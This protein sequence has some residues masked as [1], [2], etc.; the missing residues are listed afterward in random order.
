MMRS[1]FRSFPSAIV[2]AVVLA[3]A[4]AHMLHAQKLKQRVADKHAEVFDYPAMA[5]IYQGMADKGKA[6]AADLRRLAIAYKRMGRMDLAEGTYA[7]LTGASQAPQD[8]L[9]Y[10]EVLRANG[11]YEQAVEWYGR[12]LAQNPDDA[13]AQ[14]Y[15]QNP[16]LFQRLE[17]AEAGTVR[18]V[19]INSPQADLG[20][21]VLG[22]LLI[23]S[24]ARGEGVGGRS[25]YKWDLEPYLNLYSAMLKGE[26]VESPMVM[27]KELNSRY[28]DGTVSY[29]SLAHRLYFTRNNLHYGTKSLA[30]NGELKLGIYFSDVV[31]GQFGQK[32]WGVLIPFDH[33]DP[34]HNYGHPCVSH[35]GRRLYFVSDRPGGF[36]GTDI[37]Y[38]DNL[39][40]NWGA[41]QNLGPKVNTPGNEMHPFITGTGFLYFASNGHPGLGGLD[42]FRTKITEAGAGRVFN[43]GAPLNTR[44][45]DFGLIL[46]KDD[47]TGFFVSD[48]PGGQ[49]SDDIYG[50]TVR[51]PMMFLA[52]IVIDANTR[53]PIEGATILLKDGDNQHVK[54]FQ[55]ET[56]PGGRFKID[57]EYRTQYVLVANKNGYY[58]KEV[59]VNTDS[60]P[61]ED[62]VI[63]MVKYDYAAEGLVLH[64]E[65]EQPL[66][67]ATVRL[68]DGNDQLLE[69]L[70][71]DASGKYNFPLKPESD[72]R[73][74][75]ERDGFFKQSARIS[76][77]GK[78]SA[79]IY[80]DFRLF[81]LDVGTIVRLENI[82]YDYNKWNIRPDAALELDKLVLTL[83]DNPT[84][85]IELGS[86]TDCRGKDAYNMGLSEKRAKSAVDYIISKGIAKDRVRSKGYGESKPYVDCVCEKCT[87]EQHQQNRRTEFTVLEK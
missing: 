63:E 70:V 84:V 55:L 21:A 81:P 48:R 16:E 64:G 76:T 13:R 19:P 75:V 18:T 62:I 29:D 34:Q 36:G 28:H 41:P 3:L 87:E 44:H 1:A 26:H 15:V 74:R 65:T 6:D 43:V 20:L 35:D 85:K 37:W 54:R 79:I 49:G 58:Q 23:F 78:P 10:A 57:A 67:G 22:D 12:Y 50:C 11:K 82:Y 53:E 7:R 27:R 80:T 59:R 69:E 77:K 73:L 30:D 31:E 14:A 61:L 45:N 4:P 68:Y 72:Y 8:M 25:A 33:N 38:C 9:D 71:T 5:K 46:L 56:E 40:N 83:N 47:S 2:A 42:L 39:G 51:P 32:E 17:R 52:G 66:D 60:D 86:H 24:S